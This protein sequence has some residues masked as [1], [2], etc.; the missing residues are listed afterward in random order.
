MNLDRIIARFLP[1]IGAIL[2]VIG[3]GYLIYTSV[4]L[5]AGYET[6]IG[7]GIFASML[8]IGMGYSMQEKVRFY[9]DIIIG[10]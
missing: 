1:I 6:K 5:T 4:W 7:V 2:F 10:A 9:A 3:L 8:L